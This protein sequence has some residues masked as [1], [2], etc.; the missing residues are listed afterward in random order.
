MPSPSVLARSPQ[1]LDGWQPSCRSSSGS[2][3]G[4]PGG[5]GRALSPGLEPPSE[6]LPRDFPWWRRGQKA[7]PT[8]VSP[9]WPPALATEGLEGGFPGAPR[10]R[11][12]SLG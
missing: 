1:R 8:A 12:V 7:L 10:Q 4:V 5:G 2:R 6:A 11:S 9:L 3:S